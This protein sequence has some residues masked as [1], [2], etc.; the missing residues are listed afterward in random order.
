VRAAKTS[1]SLSEFSPSGLADLTPKK[2]EKCRPLEGEATLTTRQK[3]R[4]MVELS[5]QASA[6]KQ[7]AQGVSDG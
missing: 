2:V 6:A 4:R 5:K 7:I 3:A 1:F